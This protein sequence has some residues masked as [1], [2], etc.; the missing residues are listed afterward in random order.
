MATILLNESDPLRREL[1]RMRLQRQGHKVWSASHLNDIIATLHD[2]AVDLMILDLDHQRLD[3]LAAFADRWKGIKIL[4]Q[5]SSP[6][7]LQDFRCWMADQFV[8]KFNNGENISRAV[9]QLLQ[10]K[11][12]RQQNNYR[13]QKSYHYGY[14]QV[15][16]A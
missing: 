14:R 12:L 2:V 8:V 5:A 16:V 9:A 15:A 1:L 11:P 13:Q 10:Q 3:E 6:S 7:L 4:F